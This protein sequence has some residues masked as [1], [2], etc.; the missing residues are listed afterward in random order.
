[1]R[2]TQPVTR[3]LVLLGGGHSHVAVLKS[4]G[5]EPMP[6]VRLT[7]ISR[8]IHTPYSGM[9]PGHIAGFYGFDDIH[10]DLAPL[11][12]FAGAR[13]YHDEVIGID[14]D[15]RRVICRN[16]PPV[17]YDL[18][19]VD[20]GATPRLDVPGAVGNVVP[21]K[22]ISQFLAQWDALCRR[23]TGRRGPVRIGVVGEGAGG[24]ELLLAAQARLRREFAASGR[25]PDDLRFHL[26]ARSAGILPGF[27][28]AAR[29][30][31]HR[32]LDRRGVKLHP[33]S[34]VVRVEPGRL[35]VAGGG[36]IALDEI[37]WVTNAGAPPWPAEAGLA[38][39]EGGF[40]KVDA[41]LRSLSHPELFAAGDIAAVVDHPR[42]KAGVFAVRQ[43]P[44]LARN[45]RRVLQGQEPRPFRP[46]RSFLTIIGTADGSAVASRN[47]WAVE[48]GWVWA[49]KD[50]I[51]RRFMRN[52][53][54][55]P[56]MAPAAAAPGS[57]A[58]P[59]EPPDMR[60]G[61]CGAKI[62]SAVLTD[63]LGAL[64]SAEREDILVGLQAPD[65]AAVVEVPPG[66][67]MVHSIDFFRAITDDPY[68]FGR[69]AANHSL[70]DLYAMGAVP[71][72]A[73]A[74]ATLP[75]GPEDKTRELLFQLMAGARAALDEAGAALVGGH[76]GEGAEL[77]LGFAVNGLI[78]R[79]AIL[80]KAGLRPG[81]SLVLTKPLGTGVLF[82]GDMRAKAKARWVDAA[83]RSMT[84]S[85]AAAAECLRRHGA[86]AC[87]DVTGF[88]LVGHLL[89]MTTPS[90]VDAEIDLAAL[91]LL[92]GA[93]ELARQGVR[94]SLHPQNVRAQQAVR[95]AGGSAEDAR[96]ALLFDP[97]TAGG[98]LAGLPSASAPACVDELRH[99]GYA[100]AAVI[101]RIRP[102]GNRPES[103]TV[104]GG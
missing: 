72:S 97:Q 71:Q 64:P 52:Y 82:A 70:G 77:A 23:V 20:T 32:V 43:G 62:G 104:I 90:A 65:D 56:E 55:L 45:L 48:G 30:K 93:L 9:L 4:F 100:D 54:E 84:R 49:W 53:A 8:E 59:A 35:H 88:G 41:G 95:R 69:I 16:R 24:V 51:D 28:A 13:L 6:G 86:T 18:L 27:A 103:I 89:E 14:L 78:D 31:L 19:S 25:D 63:A 10:I 73:L 58:R 36:T 80:R 34:S 81:D 94:S 3:D 11:A 66:K 5:M 17:A 47:G 83:L 1:M 7:V 61:G 15:A 60:C 26:I 44:P 102:R 101:G 39:D 12:R 40:I 42:P 96:L 79:N 46:Q 67:L 99:L 87:T 74:V 50:R 37:L 92:D 38:V 29:R 85:G 21:V 98:L 91:P 2:S 57:L 76:T 75:Y 22:P 68:L 33:G